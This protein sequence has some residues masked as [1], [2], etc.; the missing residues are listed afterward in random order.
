MT[1]WAPAVLAD[2]LR[3]AL[4]RVSMPKDHYQPVDVEADGAD[5][6]L[7]LRIRDDP[8]TYVIL[9]SAQPPYL[10]KSTGEPCESPQD[11]A[12]EVW[13]MLME[14]V[15]TRSIDSARR[16]QLRGGLVRLH[17]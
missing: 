2:A 10:G 14:E 13:W 8:T 3:D 9:L 15:D 5:V 11:W 16:T 12:E 4:S 17:V 1:Q 6:R 7:T